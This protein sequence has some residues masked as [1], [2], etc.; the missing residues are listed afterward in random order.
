LTVT[1]LGRHEL[2]PKK[3]EMNSTHTPE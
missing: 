1:N 2:G 3:T